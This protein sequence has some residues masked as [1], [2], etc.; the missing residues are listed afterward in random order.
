MGWN[1]FSAF[2]Q[3]GGPIH[4][5]PSFF[6][7]FPLFPSS[8]LPSFFFPSSQLQIIPIQITFTLILLTPPLHPFSSLLSTHRTPSLVRYPPLDQH[9]FLPYIPIKKKKNP[10]RLQTSLV[11][12][13]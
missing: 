2:H 10:D 11:L 3:E 7:F 12:R 1:L 5:L 6:F 9:P 4:T 8:S 13:D